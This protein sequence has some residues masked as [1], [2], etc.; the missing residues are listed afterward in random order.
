MRRSAAQGNETLV[1]NIG[2]LSDAIGETNKAA[3]SVLSASDRSHRHGGDAV[4]RGRK[5]FHNLRS[6]QAETRKSA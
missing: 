2:S 5:F 4:A 6:G 3:A 1:T